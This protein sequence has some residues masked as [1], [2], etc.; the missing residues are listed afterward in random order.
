[1]VEKKI[2]LTFKDIFKRQIA[3]KTKKDAIGI[4]GIKPLMPE[5]NL[6]ASKR[7][8]PKVNLCNKNL[9]ISLSLW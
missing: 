8:V 5:L 7:A 1:M 2:I 9:E 6:V 3:I 4:K